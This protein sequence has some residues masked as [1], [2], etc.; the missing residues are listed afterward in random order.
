MSK[1]L[2]KEKKRKL[3]AIICKFLNKFFEEDTEEACL[4]GYCKR[5][6]DLN[7]SKTILSTPNCSIL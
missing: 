6:N 1:N 4:R 2:P 5:S 3:K 7:A